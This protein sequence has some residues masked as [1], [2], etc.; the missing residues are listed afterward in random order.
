[1][2]VHPP[3]DAGGHGRQPATVRSVVVLDSPE[4][5]VW[6]ARRQALLTELHSIDAY[7]GLPRSRDGSVSRK[8]MSVAVVAEVERFL[9]REFPIDERRSLESRVECAIRHGTGKASGEA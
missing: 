1:M 6:M 4:R 7:L 3:P 5:V 2:S 9:G 8:R